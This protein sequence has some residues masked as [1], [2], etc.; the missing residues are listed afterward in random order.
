MNSFDT[1]FTDCDGVIYT[2]TGVINKAHEAVNELI[3]A[4]KTIR[5]ITNNS[6]KTKLQVVQTLT[7]Y[8]FSNITERLNCMSHRVDWRL[9]S[10]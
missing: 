4:G 9:T 1:I 2:T 7:N 3:K 8:G 6:T 5:Y 10:K